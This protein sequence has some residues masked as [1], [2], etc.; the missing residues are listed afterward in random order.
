MSSRIELANPNLYATPQEYIEKHLAP[1]VAELHRAL[2]EVTSP[3]GDK[4][5][6]MIPLHGGLGWSTLDTH[7]DATPKHFIFDGSAYE[8]VPTE[9]LRHKQLKVQ[10]TALV[11]V[12]G[13]GS[14][15]FRLMRYDGLTTGEP[16]IGSQFETDCHEPT[17]FTLTLPFGN[18]K[19]CVA[20][21]KRSYIIE[22]RSVD[23]STIPVCRRFSMSFV[24]I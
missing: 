18:T 23:P 6:D 16:V 10:L 3:I 12:I 8:K 21:E 24:Y 11:Y 22:A 13:G 20:P 4:S 5:M 19:G 2:E 1:V 15:D 14:A 7:L 9:L 17:S